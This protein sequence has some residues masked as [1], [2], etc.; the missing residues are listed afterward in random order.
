M[1]MITGDTAT[2]TNPNVRI[3]SASSG[4]MSSRG[5]HGPKTRDEDDG[6]GNLGVTRR[7]A[8]GLQKTFVEGLAPRCHSARGL[9]LASSSYTA[10]NIAHGALTPWSRSNH[11][12]R[13]AR[14]AA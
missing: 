11:G 3:V 6:G 1:A 14:A 13:G 7:Q 5:S 12:G 10:E 8:L 4:P 9:A 2:V